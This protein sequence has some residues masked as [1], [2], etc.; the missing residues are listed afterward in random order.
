M[1]IIFWFQVISFR[2]SRRLFLFNIS[3]RSFEI[4]LLINGYIHLLKQQAIRWNSVSW[5]EVN[6]ISNNYIFDGDAVDGT[7]LSSVHCDKLFVYFFLEEKE[8][9]LLE[10]ITK[11]GDTTSEE[12]TGENGKWL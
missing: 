9:L 11:T 8:L 3:I 4:H 5:L 7:E 10:V 2:I 6:D 12:C 1:M